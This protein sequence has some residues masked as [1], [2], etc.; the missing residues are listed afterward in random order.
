MLAFGIKT[1]LKKVWGPYVV[2]LA[3]H[4]GSPEIG[5]QKW[6]N[7]HI[8]KNIWNKYVM[9]PLKIIVTTLVRTLNILLV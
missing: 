2:N 7:G 4:W 3:G 1:I 6:K 9:Q 8:S 5:Y